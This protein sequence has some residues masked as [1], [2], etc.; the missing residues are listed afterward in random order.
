MNRDL[1]SADRAL[2]LTKELGNRWLIVVS[3]LQSLV[4]QKKADVSQRWRMKEPQ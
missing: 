3:A 4:V 1:V 2:R